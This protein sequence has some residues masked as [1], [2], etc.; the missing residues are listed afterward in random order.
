MIEAYICPETAMSYPFTSFCCQG[1][2]SRLSFLRSSALYLMAGQKGP[3]TFIGIAA[4]YLRFD[5]GNKEEAVHTILS[6]K[7]L[8]VD[9]IQGMRAQDHLDHLEKVLKLFVLWEI[10]ALST[11]VWLISWMFLSLGV[12][13]ISLTLRF[14]NGFHNK[15]S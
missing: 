3:I 2:Q 15:R 9:G 4:A 8:L 5:D 12:R 13:A 1:K 14:A 10:T 6:M 7:P 11:N